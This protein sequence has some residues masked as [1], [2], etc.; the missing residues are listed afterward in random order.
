MALSSNTPRRLTADSTHRT[1]VPVIADDIVYQ[2]AYLSISSGRAAPLAAGDDFI[3]IALSF[4]D[5]AGGAAGAVDV[6]V[7]QRGQ[8]VGVSVAGSSATSFGA[9]VYASDDGTLTL[10]ST[11]NSKIG[12]VSRVNT[13]GTC[14]VNFAAAAF[15]ID[16]DT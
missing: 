10:T 13:D 9:V 16:T 12:F 5:N 1:L 11:S 7:C 14:N 2:G 4:A 3:G 8:L 6:E 15:D